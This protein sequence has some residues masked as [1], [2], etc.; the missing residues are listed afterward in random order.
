MYLIN[1]LRNVMVASKMR[2]IIVQNLFA[3]IVMLEHVKNVTIN[4]MKFCAV[5]TENVIHVEH[6]LHEVQKVGL[7]LYVKL[8]LTLF[9]IVVIVD[10]ATMIVI[11]KNI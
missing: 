10:N 6:T 9:L 3:M 1:V 8:I 4:T 5:V 7:V 11:W 2:V